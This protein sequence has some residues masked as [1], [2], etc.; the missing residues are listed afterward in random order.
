MANPEDARQSLAKLVSR[1]LKF[2][3]TFEFVLVFVFEEK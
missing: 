1:S 3:L 2:K